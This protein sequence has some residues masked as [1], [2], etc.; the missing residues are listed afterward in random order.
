MLNMRTECLYLNRNVLLGS[1]MLVPVIALT[2][3]GGGGSMDNGAMESNAPPAG[4]APTSGTPRVFFV[5]P[6][7]GAE[8]SSDFDLPLQFGSENYE[9]SPIPEEFDSPRADIGHYHFG[10]D[11]G[12]LPVGEVIPQG[13]GWVH[14]GDGSDTFSLQVEPGAY[15]LT[16]QI[17]DDEHRTQ[18]GLCETIDVEIADGI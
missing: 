17:G 4:A 1:L 3:C 5:A 10:F 14:I 15:E 18:N 11:T 12:C 6:Q 2:G 13:E 8:I 7:D 9:I 16:V